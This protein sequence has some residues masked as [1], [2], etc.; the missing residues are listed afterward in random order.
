MRTATALSTGPVTW[1]QIQPTLPHVAESPVTPAPIEREGPALGELRH[2]A[3]RFV[4]IVAEV[5]TA[6][7]PVRQTRAWF[8]PEV[9]DQLE[10]RLG[11]AHRLRPQRRG[12]PSA[13]VVSVHV[14]MVNESTAEIAGRMVHRGRS[15]AIAMRVER[16]Q[17]RRGRTVWR[18]TAL[19]W[20]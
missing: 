20:A 3:G 5:L 17:D 11:A 16:V 14:A 19:E 2:R 13:R 18:C 12:G 8:S 15:R 7:R 1:Q 4:Q 6:D 9:F 10:R